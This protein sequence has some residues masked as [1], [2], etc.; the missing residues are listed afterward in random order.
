VGAAS[1][2]SSAATA[3]T[4]TLQVIVTGA[5][6][7]VSVSAGEDCDITQTRDNGQSCLYPVTAGDQVTLTPATTTGFVGWSVFECP[8]TSSCTITVDSDRTVVA[9]FTPT[10]LTVAFE[11]SDP[12]ETVTSSDGKI[13]CPDTCT[14]GDFPAFGQVT[15][16]AAPA[17]SFDSWSGACQ[18]AGSQPTCTL[19]LSGDDVVGAKF[20]DASEDPQIVPPR[21]DVL[22]TVDVEPKG[23]GTVTSTRSRLSEAID[24][25][26]TCK[27]HFEQGE[28]PTLKAVGAD[29]GTFVGWRGG[30]RFCKAASTCHYPA[31]YITSIEAVFKPAAGCVTPRVVGLR[32]RKAKHRISK[33]LCR[34]GKVT[35]KPSSLRKKGRV[36]AQKPRPHTT[37]KQ[38]ARVN[39]VVGRGPR[40]SR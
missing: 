11:G 28:S 17:D 29:G 14:N 1:T 31:F 23:S 4:V 22:L 9:T 6:G 2:R 26:A 37:L 18:E 27:A 36:L 33:A 38:G 34:T 5:N 13:S 32:L 19:L 40:R 8:G 7:H 15:L 3:A 39:L 16:T 10:S 30:G 25:G 35:R 12:A 24:C 21:Q 20:K